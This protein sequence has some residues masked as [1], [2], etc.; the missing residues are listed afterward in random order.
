MGC[1]GGVWCNDGDESVGDGVMAEEYGHGL[2]VIV[3]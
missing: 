2:K 3:S 1:G